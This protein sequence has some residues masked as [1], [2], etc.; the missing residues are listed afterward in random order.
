MY[1]CPRQRSHSC[2]LSLFRFRIGIERRILFADFGKTNTAAITDT[3][4]K[5]QSPIRPRASGLLD[6]TPPHL[7][8]RHDAIFSAS[9]T[10]TA[11][12]SRFCEKSSTMNFRLFFL[13]SRGF[14]DLAGAIFSSRSSGL[15]QTIRLPLLSIRVYSVG[16]WRR[17]P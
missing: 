1:A 5:V 14:A 12:I 11:T 15:D 7:F 9:P 8:F 17:L 13:A 6:V 4:I 3:G 10:A 2:S 16:G